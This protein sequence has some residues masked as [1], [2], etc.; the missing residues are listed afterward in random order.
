MLLRGESKNTLSRVDSIIT[1][2]TKAL[3]SRTKNEGPNPRL[4]TFGWHV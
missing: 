4:K 1:S 3:T 2:L